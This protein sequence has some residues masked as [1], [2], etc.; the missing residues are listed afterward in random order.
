M[1]V[2][3]NFIYNVISIFPDLNFSIPSE[4]TEVFFNIMRC[5]AYFFPVKLCLPIIY[6]SL[7][8]LGVKMS[9]AIY[10]FIMYHI[11]FFK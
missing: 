7:I 10:K 1:N 2:V 3:T 5:V 4:V 6:F 8:L 9:I 11:P